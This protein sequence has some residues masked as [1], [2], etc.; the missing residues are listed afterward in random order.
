M[1]PSSSFCVYFYFFISFVSISSFSQEYPKS[2][3]G[4]HRLLKLTDKT[5]E[6]VTQS[7]TG[8]TTGKWV[9]Y[10]DTDHSLNHFLTPTLKASLMKLDKLQQQNNG[11]DDGEYKGEP[12]IAA[13]INVDEEYLTRAR[14][15]NTL[16]F[17]C[18]AVFERRKMRQFKVLHPKGDEYKALGKGVKDVE[19]WLEMSNEE[20]EG[21]EVVY[22]NVPKPLS[23]A[24]ATSVRFGMA[25]RMFNERK[26]RARRDWQHAMKAKSEAGMGAMVH[27]MEES[28]KKSPKL[29]GSILIAIALTMIASLMAMSSVLFG[30]RR[31]ASKNKE[32]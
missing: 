4:N 6:H 25:T 7:A 32:E 18:L 21:G 19:E 5:F 31:G 22:L 3:A 29:Y 13:T 11:G 2:Y 28:F 10:F 8:Q 9:V 12:F 15:E 27:E 24:K 30:G 20:F 14:F 26:L 23:M 17:P 1:S 16:T